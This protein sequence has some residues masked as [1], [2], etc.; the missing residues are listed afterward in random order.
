LSKKRLDNHKRSATP[1]GSEVLQLAAAALLA[2]AG[3]FA[4]SFDL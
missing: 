3:S 4:F 2:A 1:T